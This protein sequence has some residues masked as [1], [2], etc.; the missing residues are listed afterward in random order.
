M[1]QE[2]LARVLRGRPQAARGRRCPDDETLAAYAEGR[3]AGPARLSIEDHL[4]ECG[5]CLEHAAALVKLSDLP[6]PDVP[7]S[8]VARAAR[9]VDRPDSPG[10]VS[11][12]RW[13]MA[14]GAF[15]CITLAIAPV[16]RRPAP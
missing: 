16:L 2:E 6:L 5:F 8:L 10:L 12:W 11:R 13:A 7:S 14:A 3:L 9:L 15:A 4:S 1:D